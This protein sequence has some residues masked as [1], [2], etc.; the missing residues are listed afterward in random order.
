VLLFLIYHNF[1]LAFFFNTAI[2]VYEILNNTVLDFELMQPLPPVSIQE[3]I[4][5]DK[6]VPPIIQKQAG[7]SRIKCIRKG[8]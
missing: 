1:F 7:R 2:V 5:D 6:V 3:L 4:T 8:V